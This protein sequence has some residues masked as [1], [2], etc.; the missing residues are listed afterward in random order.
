MTLEYN[1]NNIRTLLSKGFTIQDLRDLCF[2]EED[3]KPL[4]EQLPEADTK[5]QEVIRIILEYAQR[6]GVIDTL[7]TWTEKENLAQY[8]KQGPYT[9]SLPSNEPTGPENGDGKEPEERPISPK[10]IPHHHLT[11]LK[12]ACTR[13]TLTL[14][15]GA[16]L[17]R[18]ET[19]LP[20][21]AD[22]ARDLARRY[23]LDEKLS[24]AEVAQRLNPA[25]NRRQFTDFLRDNLD[26]FN[27]PLQP[28]HQHLVAFVKRHQIGTIITTA[29]DDLLEI[30]FR[31]S[32]IPFYRVVR[33]EQVRFIRADR[34]IFIR[35]YGDPLDP[36]TLVVT[37]KDHT[38]LLRD[39]HKRDIVEEVK[40]TFLHNTILFLG[41]N[42]S[43]TNFRLLFDQVAES[44]FARTAY[45]VWPGLPEGDTVMWRDRGIIILEGAVSTLLEAI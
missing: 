31:Q 3:F 30:A 15:I 1:L 20:S 11:Q 40:R 21:R 43:D 41:Y 29:Y 17:S 10:P 32:G 28:F 18:Q 34:L 5:K 36:D 44:R 25:D 9:I 37:D 42:L 26:S 16:D 12:D 23:G 4:H 14:F 24:L 7:L 2:Y 39:P 22:L 45:A 6:M 19:G 33:D 13:R 27:K 8:K 35:L 38:N